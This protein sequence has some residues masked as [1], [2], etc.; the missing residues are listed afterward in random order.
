VDSEA[1]AYLLDRG[2]GINWVAPWEDLTPRDA[3]ERG[4]RQ[5]G[6][7]ARE[8]IGWLR[9]QGARRFDEGSAPTVA[10]DRP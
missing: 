10:P 6:V 5:N 9:R 4:Q 8:L 7:D 1:A 2:A 3:A